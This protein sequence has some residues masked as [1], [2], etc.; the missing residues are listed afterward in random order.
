MARKSRAA[1]QSETTKTATEQPS[2]LE[3]IRVQRLTKYKHQNSKLAIEVTK[4]KG[5]VGDVETI[6]REVLAA[7]ATVKQ[8]LLALPYRLNDTLAS[9]NEPREVARLLTQAIVEA[10]NDLAYGELYQPEED[11]CPLC[12]GRKETSE[13]HDS[14]RTRANRA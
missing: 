6:K 2:T 10:L 1:K 14:N 11:I 7:N 8:Q 4:L 9:T 5:Q 3:K 12:S 13:N